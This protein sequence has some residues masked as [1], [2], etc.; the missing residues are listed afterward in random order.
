MALKTNDIR[1]MTPDEINHK[2]FSLQEELFKL[3]FERKAGRI[4]KPHRIRQTK[5]DLARLYTILKEKDNAEKQKTKS[6]A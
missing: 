6:A 4:E 2:I 5:K 1:N 3:R